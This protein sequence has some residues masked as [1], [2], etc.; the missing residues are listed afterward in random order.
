MSRDSKSR[1]SNDETEKDIKEWLKF[2]AERNMEQVQGDTAES[3][4]SNKAAS[5][6]PATLKGGCC[7]T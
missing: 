3:S 1:L 2:S 6:L 4:R 7:Q 5:R